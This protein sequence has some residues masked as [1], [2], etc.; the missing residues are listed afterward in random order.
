MVPGWFLGGVGGYWLGWAEHG[1]DT[2]YSGLLLFTLIWTFLP[3]FI[4]LG[5]KIPKFVI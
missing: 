5:P 2:P 4:Q 3:S 1:P